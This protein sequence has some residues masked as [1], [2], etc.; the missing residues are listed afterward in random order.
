MIYSRLQE[1]YSDN[2]A[3]DGPKNV[4]TDVLGLFSLTMM[5]YGRAK[6]GWVHDR[7]QPRERRLRVKTEDF[8]YHLSHL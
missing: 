2:N 3:K 8:N 5:P 7:S 6:V 4:F 1:V